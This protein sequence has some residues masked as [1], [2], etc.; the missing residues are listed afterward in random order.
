MYILIISFFFVIYV[1][2]CH[3]FLF[4]VIIINLENIAWGFGDVTPSRRRKALH[5]PP[6]RYFR[7]IH[8]CDK[9]S[10][11]CKNKL[12]MLKFT[13]SIYLELG[14]TSPL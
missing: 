11:N 7:D 2:F 12:K 9:Q 5:D 4:L 10:K 14:G 8:R 3:F 6:T 1:F 13:N